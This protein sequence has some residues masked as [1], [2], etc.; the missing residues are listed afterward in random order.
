MDLKTLARNLHPLE[1]KVVPF[2]KA[3]NDFNDLVGKTGMQEVEVMRALQWLSNRDILKIHEQ[4]KDSLTLGKNG[5]LYKEKGLPERRFLKNISEKPIPLSELA[6]KASLDPAEV[7]ICLGTLKGKAAINI[8]KEKELMISIAENG[9]K[10]AAKETLEERFLKKPFPIDITTLKAEEKFA[11]DSLKKR[12]DILMLKKLK[13]KTIELTARGKE[14]TKIKIDSKNTLDKLTPSILKTGSW[15]K[16]TFR[17]YDV[18][19][20]V[21]KVYGG[22]RHFVN[23]S[24]D[25]IRKIWL[26]LGFTEMTGNMIQTSFWDLDSLFVPQDHPARQ[27]Q[28][29][30]YIKD[31]KQ[32]KLPPIWKKI[33]DVHEN[34]ADTG[35]KGWGG[36]WSEEIAKEN[37]LRTHT[38]VLS[39]QTLA[40]IKESD[41]P[42][43]FFSVGKVFRNEALDYK[44]LFEFYQVEGIVVDPDADFTNLKGYLK[45]FFTKMGFLDV[46]IRPAHFPYTEPSAEVE[47][48]HPIHKEWVELGGAGI[49]RPELTKPLIGKEIPV[50]AWGLGMGRTISEYWKIKDIRELYKNDLKQMREMKYWMK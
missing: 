49:F 46:R 13:I 31:P 1:R 30:F 36:K 11:F 32:G 24:V 43:K 14:L 3:T 2:L 21:P 7:N 41:L 35:S 37:L 22:K 8:K 18:T 33:K 16:K 25:Y 48:L 47:V 38:T 29:T 23:Q 5:L 34:G 6:R 50:L 42:A 27:M 40:K 19:I 26:E 39:A 10:L 44:H 20:N 4:E 17:E 12:K 28:D 9:K 45:E 15:K